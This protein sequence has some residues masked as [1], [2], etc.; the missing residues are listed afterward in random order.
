MAS[1]GGIGE[2]VKS[3]FKLSPALWFVASA[4]PAESDVVLQAGQTYQEA[5][6]IRCLWFWGKVCCGMMA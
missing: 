1:E 5:V 4:L 3:G 2:P 6:G